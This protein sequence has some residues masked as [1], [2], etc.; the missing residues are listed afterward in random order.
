MFWDTK[1]FD[2]LNKS[3]KKVL[4]HNLSAASGFAAGLVLGYRLG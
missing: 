4:K 3:A 1:D 2:S